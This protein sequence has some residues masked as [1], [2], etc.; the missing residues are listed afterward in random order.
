L[1]KGKKIIDKTWSSDHKNWLK[2]VFCVFPLQESYFHWAFGVKEPDC[3]GAI[4]VDTGKAM[5]F[6]PELDPAYIVWMG[7]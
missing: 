3:Y 2:K 4:E 1:Y 6:V 5:L 7:K